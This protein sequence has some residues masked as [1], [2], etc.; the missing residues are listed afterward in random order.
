MTILAIIFAAAMFAFGM[1]VEFRE[2]RKLRSMAK[3]V[4]ER[5]DGSN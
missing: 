3:E 4:Q 5:H 2:N 1:W